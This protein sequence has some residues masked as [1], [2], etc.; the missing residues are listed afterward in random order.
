[1]FYMSIY[2]SNIW[3]CGAYKSAVRTK[4]MRFWAIADHC[5]VSGT[6][7]CAE[8]AGDHIELSAHE[9]F[10]GPCRNLLLYAWISEQDG[11]R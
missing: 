8:K 11:A 4:H 2:G 10:Q 7:K 9:K 5:Q 6:Y 1:M 3:A